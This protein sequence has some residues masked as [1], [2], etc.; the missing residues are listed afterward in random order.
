MLKKW[1][2]GGFFIAFM[3]VSAAMAAY[4]MPETI[5]ETENPTLETLLRG[6]WAPGFEKAL[7][8][9]LPVSDPVR[10]FWGRSEYA[11][12]GQGRKGVLVG[13]DGWLFTDEE[14]ACPKGGQER[15]QNNLSYIASMRDALAQRGIDL[16]VVLIPAKARLYPAYLGQNAVPHCR[17]GLYALTL[18]KLK[19]KDI[20]VIDLISKMNASPDKDELFLKTDTHWTPSG[21]RFVAAVAAKEI[22]TSGFEKKTYGVTLQGD[23][24]VHEGD[25][26]RYVPGVGDEDIARDALQSYVTD[27]QN[28][29]EEDT[30]A[31]LF[32]D[33]IPPVT[34]V[35]TSYS[36]NPSWHFLGF[37]KEA[38]GVD[39]LDMSD[40][41]RGPFTVMEKY[42]ESDALKNTPPKLVIWEI[43]ERYMMS[44][45]ALEKAPEEKTKEK[46]V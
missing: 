6:N 30:A 42:M 2:S 11:L 44:D 29:S 8:E 45:P 39:I 43:P 20:K 28:A 19:S 3:A 33:D 35:G 27:V 26:L 10:D 40:E 23:K 4:D 37:L 22:D 12:F 36:A 14:F 15:F 9:T 25:L 34:L 18:L 7:N 17:S 46:E 38:L 31:S 16:A 24:S 41:G 5:R 1:M 32:G 21:A 13:A